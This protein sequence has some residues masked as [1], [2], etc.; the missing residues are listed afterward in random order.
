MKIER[1]LS[2]KGKLVCFSVKNAHVSRKGL[3]RMIA[4]LDGVSITK[5]PKFFD[6]EVFCEFEFKGGKFLVDEPWG[7][8]PTY[9]IYATEAHSD[10]MELLANHIENASAIID[11]DW[12]H[13][14]YL[15]LTHII[16]VIL[17]LVILKGLGQLFA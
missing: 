12:G 10:E 9:E 11:G 17:L 5:K 15:L 8:H 6:G 16:S 13:K 2:E 4:A 14:L 1:N 3:M 7:D